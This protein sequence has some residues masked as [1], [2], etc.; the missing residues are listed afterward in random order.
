M[1]ISKIACGLMGL[2]AL[3]L[4]ACSTSGER[5]S[6]VGAGVI[7]GGSVA[8]PPGAVVGGIAGAIEGPSVA[9]AM[10]VPH[11]HWH[12]RHWRRY[13]NYS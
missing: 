13:H 8:G 4:G 7:V 9:N 10:G 3:S 2:A 11:R 12:R 5:L 6:G 1:A